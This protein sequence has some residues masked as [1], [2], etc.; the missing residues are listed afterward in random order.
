MNKSIR[1]Q[2]SASNDL[3]IDIEQ[4]AGFD[5]IEVGT[6]TNVDVTVRRSGKL[7]HENGE[8][9]VPAHYRNC[10]GRSV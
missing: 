5:Q 8:K 9:H 3:K 6:I 7:I 1:K 10:S 4:V 2:Q